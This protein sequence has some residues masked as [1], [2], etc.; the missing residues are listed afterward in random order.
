MASPKEQK[1]PLFSLTA[2]VVGSM[3]GAGIFNLPGR[4]A[5][6][7]GPF[8]AVIAWAI[9]GTG[10]YMLARVFQALAEKRV[11]GYG[12]LLARSGVGYE[13][14]P[15]DST[16]FSGRDWE[17]LP[18]VTLEYVI[19]TSFLGGEKIANILG[20]P[21]LDFQSSY[22]KVWSNA[23]GVSFNQWTA[24]ATIKMGWRF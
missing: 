9:A 4:F 5:T 22:L 2:M 20:R 24:S 14:T 1:L 17:A 13:K 11:A 10:M 18:I 7:T 15:D 12:V 16:G 23:P 8:G 6:A 3:V 19:P 21:S